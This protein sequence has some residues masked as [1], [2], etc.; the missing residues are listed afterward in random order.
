M[1]Q[2]EK[3]TWMNELLGDELIAHLQYKL[4]AEIVVGTDYDSCA[5]EFSKHADEE[6]EHFGEL[7]KK[8]V[9]QH[10]EVNTGLISLIK[11]S[12]SGYEKMSGT[13]SK[14]LCQFHLKAEQNAVKAYKK[15]LK[16]LEDS[17]DFGLRQVIRKILNDE[18][19]HRIDLE[20]I[21]SSIN[22]DSTMR[23]SDKDAYFSRI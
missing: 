17:D 16:A 21:L 5:T 19:E 6:Y 10:M 7:L 18:L 23:S 4:A 22:D 8:M 14:Y 20:K 13:S 3:E 12:Y 9:E 11:R 1:T 2:S 15:F